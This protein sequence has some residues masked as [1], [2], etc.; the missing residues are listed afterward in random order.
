MPYNDFRSIWLSALDYAEEQRDLYHSG[1]GWQTWME[2]YGED[3]KAIVDALDTIYAMAH[4]GCKAI[5]AVAGLSRK[6]FCESYSL[7]IRT[8]ED[9]EA[10]RREPP[11]HT[12]MMLAFCIFSDAQRKTEE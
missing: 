4:G 3:T 11:A 6:A 8:V 10:D 12:L 5:R 9:W 7:P 1:R 2:E